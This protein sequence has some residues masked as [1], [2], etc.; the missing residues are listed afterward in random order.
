MCGVI[1]IINSED[2]SLKLFYGLMSLQHRG[3]DA[4]GIA[5]TK[6]NEV[7]LHKNTGLVSD[8]FCHE[9]LSE[10]KGN[11]GIGHTR[12]STVGV[13]SRSNTQPL[14]V[15]STRKIAM[16]HNGNITNYAELQK[17]L[18][19]K[20]IFF[21]STV[22]VEPILRMF[23]YKYEKTK[24]FFAASDHV[25]QNVKGAYSIVGTIAG[26]GLFAI[27]DPNGIRPLCMG[28]NG[29]SYVFA[30]ESAA[31][32]A[33]GYD[34]V[35]D[36]SPGE[37]IL[38]KN[39]GKDSAS[40]RIEQRILTHRHRAHCMFEWV[41]FASPQ[42]MIE[43]RAVYKARLSLGVILAKKLKGEDIDVVVPIPDTSR[44]CAIKLAE[45]LGVKYR[46]GLIKHRYVGRTFITPSQESRKYLV[47]LKLNVIL[48]IIKGKNICLVDD[49]IVRGTTSKKIVKK[50]RDAGAK[51]IIFV[52]SCPPIKYPC[53]YGIDMSTKEELIASR[54]SIDEIRRYIGADKLV[55]TEIDDLKRAIR[56]DI[57]TACL[58]KK[59]P[60]RLSGDQR[61]FFADDKKNR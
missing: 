30:S 34:F 51:R 1:G 58:D 38:I 20:G 45:V 61:L 21:I 55:Y 6:D 37:A 7:Y 13:S 23:A 9:D 35:R 26:V 33:I 39:A 54:R 12:Y 3:Q 59:Y 25:M 53:F 47:N 36:V 32:Q 56:R 31:L 52:S 40:P 46:E 43:E 16:A 50:L 29:D 42:S 28:K 60:I 18:T 14:Y 41:Y 22:D 10:L 24:D 44:S 15:N 57:C 27:R 8:V 19:R 17:I 2:V 5:T 11:M 49:S 4:A 48:S